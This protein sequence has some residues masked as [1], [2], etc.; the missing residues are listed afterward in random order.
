MIDRQLP[1]RAL[2]PSGVALLRV[3]GDRW[4]SVAVH[5]VA[6]FGVGGLITAVF[7]DGAAVAVFTLILGGL[8][9][10]RVLQLP[11]LLQVALGLAM[12]A[13]AWA[14]ML[15]WYEQYWWLD[16]VAHLVVNG[17]LAGA[18]GVV[19]HRAQMTPSRAARAGRWGSV[20]TTTGVGGL[21]AV[22]WEVAE[23]FGYVYVDRTIDIAPGD[24]VG[25]LAAGVVGSVIAGLVLVRRRGWQ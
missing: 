25:D 16:I 23:W 7:F 15:R 11:A 17:L 19:L 2:T 5:V 6:A 18:A 4:A 12:Q 3:P 14:S 8:T 13:A 1:T 24:T 21:L 20:I 9:L 10:I 22:V